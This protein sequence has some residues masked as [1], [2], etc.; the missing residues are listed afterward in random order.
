MDQEY[1]PYDHDND[2]S[3]DR[4][5]QDDLNLNR[6]SG[7]DSGYERRD[8]LAS[9][10]PR[11]MSSHEGL[12]Y[13][14]RYEQPLQ[15][16]AV[17]RPQTGHKDLV[18]QIAE[19]KNQEE[20]ME[21]R[22][23]VSFQA[24]IFFIA[25]GLNFFNN[26]RQQYI[27]EVIGCFSGNCNPNAN[28]LP[29]KTTCDSYRYSITISGGIGYIFLGNIYDN[30]DSPRRVTAVLLMILS[31]IA[32][33]EAIFANVEEDVKKTE[34]LMTLYQ[35]SSVFEAGISL[36]CIV[37]IHNWFKESILGIVCACWLTATY[38]QKISQIATY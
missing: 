31:I 9:D 4:S 34:V 22:R 18:E 30:V 17:A 19:Q 32:L 35:M 7:R 28:L 20:T 15:V 25:F 10:E 23:R 27:Y 13:S 14:S 26:M 12:G 1:L 36:A 2:S 21:T 29:T 5:L 8:S 33:V 38:L 6:Y 37:I 3:T 24:F 16:M 11:R